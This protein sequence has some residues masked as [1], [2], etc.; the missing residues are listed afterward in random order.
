MLVKVEV[1]TRQGNLLSLPLEDISDGIIVGDIEGLDPVKA[2]L[3]SSSFAGLDGQQYQSS[4]RDLRNIR[5]KLDLDPDPTDT[6]RDLRNR[7]YGFFMPKSEVDLRFYMEDGLTVNISGRVE[8]FEAQLFTAEPAADISIICF[9]PDFQGLAPVVISGNTVST[10]AEFLINY[11]GT[12]ETGI[13]FTLLPNRTLTEFAIYHRAPDD[14]MRILE[15]A[16]PLAVGDMLNI[17][18]VSGSKG[19]TL[20]RTGTSTSVLYGISPQSNW[21]ELASGPNYFT[22][23][24][25]GAAIP[26]QIK[27]VNKYGGL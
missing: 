12:V 1:R 14:T 8:S 4:R 5:I 22:V 3:V 27:Y 21:T 24:A 20:L 25:V 15:F 6:V 2:T 17:S 19:A 18:T 9:D 16:A 11:E 13:E 10:N 23:Y 7:L 26:F